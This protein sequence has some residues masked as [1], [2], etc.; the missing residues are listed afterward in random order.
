MA[1]VSQRQAR[2]TET[3]RQQTMTLAAV[4]LLPVKALICKIYVKS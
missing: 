1:I 4:R 3:D 2:Q